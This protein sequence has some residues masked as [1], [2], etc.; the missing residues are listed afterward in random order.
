MGKYCEMCHKGMMSGNNVS[1]AKNRTR[2]SWA[3]NTQNVHI[4]VDGAKRTMYV[5]TRCL[6]SLRKGKKIQAAK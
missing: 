1:H 4:E 3:P 2:R 6:R 5:C